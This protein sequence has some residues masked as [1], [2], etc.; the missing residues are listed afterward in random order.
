[1]SQ[2]FRVL[3]SMVKIAYWKLRYG[4]RIQVPMIQGFDRVYLELHGQGKL[5]LG[6]H[7]QNRG[8]LHLICDGEGVLQIGSH[9]YCNTNNCI[10]CMGR[11]TIGDYCKLGNNLVVV[12]HDHN[13]KDNSSE[14]LVGEVEIGSH[15][16]IGANCTILRGTRIGDSCVIA[17]GSVVKGEV[18]AGTVFCQKRQTICRSV[19]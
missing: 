3:K 1:M 8:E 18:P 15:V 10:T 9:V 7:I 2:I 14:Y 11:V 16:W 12:D 4:K 6:D 17:A 19:E 5:H 13:F